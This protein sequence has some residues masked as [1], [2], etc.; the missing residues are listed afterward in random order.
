MKPFSV[1]FIFIVSIHTMD[2]GFTQSKIFPR[3]K[4]SYL[5]QRPPGKTPEIFG[6][7][8]VSTFMNEGTLVASPDGKEIF[9]VVHAKLGDENKRIGAIVTMKE[10]NGFWST[11]RVASFSGGDYSDEYLTMHPNGHRIYFNSNRQTGRDDL[12]NEW[13]IWSVKKT[14]AGWG[15]AK[16]LDPPING[17]GNVTCFSVAR[18]NNAYFTLMTDEWDRIFRSKYKDGKYQEPEALPENINSMSS[19]ADSYISPD[20]DYLLVPLYKRYDSLGLMDLYVSFRDKHD[21]WSVL[22]NLGPPI[23]TKELDGSAT[24]SP[25]GKYI[26]LSHHYDDMG[27]VPTPPYI[28]SDLIKSHNKA[29]VSHGI[30]HHVTDIYWIDASIIEDLKP[31]DS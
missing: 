2:C 19:Q 6:P 29:V 1:V 12:T 23:N 3:L 13:N 4:G 14:E 27:K 30:V 9:W 21:N 22:I 20:E 28:Y 5:G 18:N 7:G 15:D 8:I 31:G 26:F 25:D 11:S 16:P 10:E 17:R 24:I